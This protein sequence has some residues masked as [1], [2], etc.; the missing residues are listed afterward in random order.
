MSHHVTICIPYNR[1]GC[2]CVLRMSGYALLYAFCMEPFK[3]LQ[4][5]LAVLQYKLCLCGTGHSWRPGTS[6]FNCYLRISHTPWCDY[7]KCF[8]LTEYNSSSV[9]IHVASSY[10]GTR[11]CT[12]VM[13]RLGPQLSVDTSKLAY[14]VTDRYYHRAVGSVQALSIIPQRHT[15][16]AVYRSTVNIVYQYQSLKH[17][18]SGTRPS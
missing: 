3:K 7:A 16:A 14:P 8:E 18:S 12:L 11:L 5:E 13:Y 10:T 17:A 1:Y 15:A 9:D 6:S 2:P 4:L